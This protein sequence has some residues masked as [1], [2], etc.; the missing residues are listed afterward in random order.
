MKNNKIAI[1]LC[2][3]FTMFISINIFEVLAAEDNDFYLVEIMQALNNNYDKDIYNLVIQ[4]I[5]TEE[6]FRLSFKQIKQVWG[7]QKEYSYE[8]L[9]EE[10]LTNK[11][12]HIKEGKYQIYQIRTS[13]CNYKVRMITGEMDNGQRGIISFELQKE[14]EA[15]LGKGHEERIIYWGMIFWSIVEFGISIYTAFYCFKNRRKWWILWLALILLLHGG[16]SISTVNGI[17]IG[18]FIRVL[19]MTKW[20]AYAMGGIKIYLSLPIGAIL[21]YIKNNSIHVGS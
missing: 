3:I 6:E 8:L 20:Q 4:D 12:M 16:I 5:Q 2:V 7:E 19:F 11:S 15:G 18:M 1:F 21:Y 10:V 9:K 17:S 14:N 13:N